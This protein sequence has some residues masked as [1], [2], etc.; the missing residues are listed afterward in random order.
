[1]KAAAMKGAIERRQ[2]EARNIIAKESRKRHESICGSLFF[3][4]TSLDRQRE[5]EEEENKEKKKYEEDERRRL[6]LK[7]E[8]LIMKERSMSQ[9]ES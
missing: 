8:M 7:N 1:M 9:R 6:L 5:I 4:F 3:N 2:Q